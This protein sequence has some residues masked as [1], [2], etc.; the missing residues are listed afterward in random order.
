MFIS[1]SATPKHD[2]KPLLCSSRSVLSTT[3]MDF[4][5]L[6]PKA[7]VCSNLLEAANGKMEYINSIIQ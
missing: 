7:L 5:Y 1:H 6:Q 3:M 2:H 4:L